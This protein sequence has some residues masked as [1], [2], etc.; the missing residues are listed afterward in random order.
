MSIGSFTE[1]LKDE[2]DARGWNQ[3]ELARRAGIH[4]SM[5]SLVLSGKRQASAD[6]CFAISNGLRLPPEHVFRRA[7]LLPPE[8]KDDFEGYQE[9]FNILRN[10]PEEDRKEL[11]ALARLKY[12]RWL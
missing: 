10:L 5:V 2:M 11:M 4:R 6:F 8:S 3:S 7:G 9:W 12:D 1:W